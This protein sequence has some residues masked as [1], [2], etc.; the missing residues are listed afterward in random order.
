[1]STA[2]RGAGLRLGTKLALLMTALI[3]GIAL[4]FYLY[5]PSRLE[6]QALHAIGGK[7]ETIG[8]L[9]AFAVAPALLFGDTAGVDEAL[10]GAVQSSDLVYMIV[11]DV[12]GRRISSVVRGGGVGRIYPIATP[13]VRD[14]RR[15]GT[16]YLGL[17]LSEL[18]PEIERARRTATVVSL[19]IF[20]AGMVAVVAIS[21]HMVEPLGR[22]VDTVERIAAGDLSVRARA[23]G[24]QEV[25]RL[26]HAFN[27]MVETLETVQAQLAAT[28][29]DL[30]RRVAERTAQAEAASQAKSEFLANMSHEIRTPMNGVLGMLEL[31]LD[32]QLTAQ[33]REYLAMAQS[34]ADALLTIINDIL[35][36]SK[37]EAGKLTL[38]PVPFHLGE[39]LEGTLSTLALRAHK[40]GLELSCHTAPTVPETLVGDEGRLRQVLLNLVGNAIKFTD[41]GEV[42]VE[43]A[44][45]DRGPTGTLLR[46]AV[47]DTGIGIPES[48]QAHIF[49]AFAQ[50]DGSTTRHYGGTGLG[51]AI[52]AQLVGLMGGRLWVDSREGQGSTF[53]F[54]ARFGVAERPAGATAPEPI[55]LHGLPVLVVDDHATTRRILCEMLASWHMCPRAFEGAAGGLAALRGAALAGERLPLLLLDAHM[56]GTDGFALA[57]TIRRDPALAGTMIIMMTTSG[58]GESSRCRAV[59]AAAQVTKPVRQSSLLDAIMT[60]IGSG[61]R[62]PAS[63]VQAVPV[64]PA[65]RPLHVLLAEDNPV[66]QQ[67][68]VGLLSRRGHT[69]RVAGNGRLAVEALERERFDVILMDVQMP[70]MSGFEATAEIRRRERASGAHVP[71]VA[72][73]ARAMAGDKE[74]CLAAGMD[75]YT[76]KPLRTRELF[77][78]LET[79]TS[80]GAPAR[81]ADDRDGVAGR[82]CDRPA[83]DRAALLERFDGSEELLYEVAGA[84][85][86]VCPA[87][88]E[89]VDEAVGASDADRVHRAAHSL[90]GS[91]ANF[92]AAD[93][94]ASALRLERMGAAGDLAEAPQVLAELRE[95]VGRLRDGLELLRSA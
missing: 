35:D 70:E 71:I 1:M 90:K 73:T 92:D 86:E 13:V 10:A 67:L 87:L 62:A 17:S 53:H 78:L 11:L 75:A 33:Q 91:V 94:V 55:E 77:D 2:S 46:F 34:S 9:T 61:G 84:F 31:A 49:D 50:A 26:V 25:T 41:T 68:A 30:E 72:L 80:G 24:G 4:F 37:I 58:E 5:V 74:R 43:V 48:K 52:S 44:L 56:P 40:K 12:H 57:G 69:V 3:G 60:T 28:N 47:S 63:P 59:G 39:C 14:G 85:L 32:T 19:V 83:V 7:A 36:F 93:A 15:L 20:L 76:T 27:T 88:L 81:A 42:L 45:E 65:A 16:L 95:S 23:A 21:T 8:E 79:L 18:R 64:E 29:Q 82:P 22:M 6:R 38:D 89:A 66:N 54:T 51:L